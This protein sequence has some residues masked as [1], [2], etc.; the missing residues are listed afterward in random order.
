M[1]E[2]MLSD[3]RTPRPVEMTMGTSRRR[4]PG[5]RNAGIEVLILELVS[6]NI[7]QL[8]STAMFIDCR[9]SWYHW[10]RLSFW[11]DIYEGSFI[12]PPKPIHWNHGRSP[13]FLRSGGAEDARRGGRTSAAV[14]HLTESNIALIDKKPQEAWSNERRIGICSHGSKFGDWHQW[15]PN[16]SEKWRLI[17]NP[18]PK[19][20]ANLLTVL[21]GLGC[22]QWLS[23][24][25][26]PCSRPTTHSCLDA[27]K[28]HNISQLSLLR[29]ETTAYQAQRAWEPWPWKRF[30]WKV[31]DWDL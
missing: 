12:P 16:E 2:G 10:Y 22:A 14:M 26:S 17:R 19:K 30:C 31:V 7:T 21:V 27:S 29:P 11:S 1:G 18:Y 5:L 15:Y 4:R 23:H 13:R 20:W 9:F 6:L 3:C 28:S 24:I 25:C 8:S